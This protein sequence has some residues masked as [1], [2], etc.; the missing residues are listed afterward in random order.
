MYKTFLLGLLGLLGLGLA[1]QVQAQK[2]YQSDSSHWPDQPIPELAVHW[3][4]SQHLGRFSAH[5]L[6]FEHRLVDRVNLEYALGLIYDRNVIED[7]EIYFDGK[8]GFKSGVKVK[9]YNRSDRSFQMFYGLEA[10]F[11]HRM[12]ERTRTFELNCSAGCTYFEQR[13]YDIE[14]NTLGLRLN[15]GLFSPVSSR[16]YIEMEAGMG[17]QYSNL[18]S[19]GKPEGVIRTYG[20]LLAEDETVTNYSLNVNIKLAYRIK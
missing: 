11:N 4:A 9:F 17:L 18:T 10:F 12:Y 15:A 16:L 13:T 1:F 14:N 6:A 3:V 8:Q 5:M 20:R 7:D 19:T 2:V